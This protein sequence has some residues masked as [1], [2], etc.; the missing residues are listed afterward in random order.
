[1]S[2]SSITGSACTRPWA[3]APRPRRGPA[4]K[5]STCARPRDVLIPPL[6]S[7]GGGPV[8]RLV[9]DGGPAVRLFP[10]EPAGDL[11]RRPAGLQALGD[12]RAQALVGR[13][14]AAPLP[15][16]A[17]QV[18]G[19]QG[20]VAAEAAVAVP[21]AVAAQLPVDRRG[22]TAEP[23]GDLAG[24]PAGLDHTEEGAAFIEVEVTV[25]PGQ[26]APPRCN[27]LG[28]LGIRTSR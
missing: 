12:A 14:L 21:E 26:E 4:W 7:S 8:D 11:L 27:P 3:T 25:G 18:L 19:V 20:E 9:T 28:R 15:A 5:G 10:L 2:R 13:Q 24:R 16:S 17:R 1:M 22:T 6:H 23:R